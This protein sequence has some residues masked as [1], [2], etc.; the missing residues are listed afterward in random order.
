MTYFRSRQALLE[1]IGEPFTSMYNAF[2]G[3]NN[4]RWQQMPDEYCVCFKIRAE[5]WETVVP[6]LVGIFNALINLSDLEDIEAIADEQIIYKMLWLELQ[7]INNSDDV[8]DWKVNPEIVKDYYNR[9]ISEALP[10]Y[11][12][13]VIS[14]LPIREI[15]FPSDAA[16]DTTKVQKATESVLNTSGGAQI[17]NSAS[18]SG[19]EAFR[20]AMKS[21]T[22]F[23]LGTLLSQIQSWVNRFMSYHVKTPCEVKF[24]PVSPYTK[25]EFRK[26]LLESAQNSI[27]VKLSYGTLL[28]YS[29]RELLAMNFLEEKCLKISD[30]F[31]PL[32]T[33]YT[34]S[35]KAESEDELEGGRPSDDQQTT[36][37]EASEDKRDRSN[38]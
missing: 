37:G 20:A 31:V 21:D 7:T 17:L 9:M 5:D 3:D 27:P 35:G 13:A 18:I 4:E 38:G 12:T 19:A 2:G 24:F 23:G 26:G 25:D 16:S 29:E 30:I 10:D 32:S 14:P 36:D 28:G 11:A 34:Q 6:P 8:D 22:A 33:S 15:S 1:L